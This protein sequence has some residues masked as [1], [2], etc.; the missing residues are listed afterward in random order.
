MS[1]SFAWVDPAAKT[2][3]APKQVES[4]NLRIGSLPAKRARITD[5]RAQPLPPV[6]NRFGGKSFRQCRSVAKHVPRGAGTNV[7]IPATEN[8]TT[9]LMLVCRPSQSKPLPLRLAAS[10]QPRK[11]TSHWNMFTLLAMQGSISIREDPN[12]RFAYVPDNLQ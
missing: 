5:A 3:A 2:A 10:S 6:G 7:S 9:K 1:S 8:D 11:D 4:R 12:I